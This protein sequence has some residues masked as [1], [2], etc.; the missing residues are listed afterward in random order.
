LAVSYWPLIK[1]AQLQSQAS[2]SGIC[3]GESDIGTGFAPSTSLFLSQYH[4]INASH[5]FIHSFV[6]DTS[7]TV[8]LMVGP[9]FKILDY[10]FY[11]YVYT[12]THTK[13]CTFHLNLAD[14]PE[15]GN[16]VRTCWMVKIYSCDL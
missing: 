16:Q 11:L 8:I 13:L 12:H 15:N 6:T 3:D 10:S 4:S 7:Y 9:L 2:E 1:E 14:L 5:S